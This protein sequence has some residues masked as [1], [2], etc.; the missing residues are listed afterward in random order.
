MKVL[1]G[2]VLQVGCLGYVRDLIQSQLQI[3]LATVAEDH[4]VLPKDCTHTRKSILYSRT[5]EVGPG[6]V[7]LVSGAVQLDLGSVQ[8][9]LGTITLWLGSVGLVHGSVKL[10]DGSV[11][12]GL[13]SVGFIH[14]SVSLR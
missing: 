3:N 12:L 6:S 1:R 8:L 2:W 11:G 9:K 4:R 13:D 5:P 10:K 7:Q 14:G